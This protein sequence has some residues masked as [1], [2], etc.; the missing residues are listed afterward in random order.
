MPEDRG[1][2][3]YVPTPYD[4]AQQM[5]TLAGVTH[6]DVVFELG[7]G[8]ARIIITALQAGG[9]RRGIAEYLIHLWTVK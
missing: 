9:A 6:D 8:D 4:V 7:C 3:I 2:V 5:V 1:E